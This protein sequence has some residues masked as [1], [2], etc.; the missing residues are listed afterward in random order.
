MRALFFAARADW[1]RGRDDS[2]TT[3]A[4]AADGS[5]AFERSA[6]EP[7]VAAWVSAIPAAAITIAAIVLLGPLLGRWLFPAPHMRFWP[8]MGEDPNPTQQARFL[9]SLAAPILLVAI[10]LWLV[11]RVPRRLASVLR[12]VAIGTEVLAVVAAVVCFV[13]QR[14]Q[15]PQTSTDNLAPVGRVVYF[16]LPSVVVAVAIAV[17]VSVGVRSA[18]VHRRAARWLAESRGRRRGALAAASVM[19]AVALLPAINSDRSITAAYEA[20]SYHLQFTY[21]ET[22]AVVDGRSPLGN[23][24][25]QYAALWPYGFALAMSIFGSGVL[26]FTVL[27]AALTGSMLLAL[28]DVLRHLT[29]SSAAS[30]ALFLPLL[31]T[32]GFRLHGPAVN[33]FSLINYFGVMPLRYA[34]P[35]LVAW[36]LTRHL[37]GA[38]PRRIWPLFLAAGL[39]ALNNVDFGVPALGATIAA[40][41]WTHRRRRERGLARALG[42]G[43]AGLTAALVL[44]NL[45]LLARTGSPADLSLLFRYARIFA[46]G[47]FAMYPIQP[48]VG[49]DLVIFLTYVAA[50]GTA[51]VR[52]L[53]GH[54]DALTGL[55]AWSGTF[56][57]GAG[58]YYVGHS[59]SEVLIDTFP[60]WA[61]SVTLLTL[62]IIRELGRVR[63][64]PTPAELACLV[65]LGLLVCSLAQIPL[66]WQQIQRITASAPPSFSHPDAEF[67]VAQNAYVGES[68]LIIAPLGHRIAANLDLKDVE[69]YT[70]SRSIFTVEQLE[71][72]LA[73][74]RAS[75]GTRVFAERVNTYENYARVLQRRFKV[76]AEEERMRLWVAR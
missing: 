6:L 34:G 4:E 13:A 29:R 16:T 68:V 72:S 54:R 47:G 43:I 58:S 65:G 25:S 11:R 45:L 21:D 26:V 49:L 31:A 5:D 51:T 38:R 55:L 30:L 24:A 20:V 37:D 1:P 70:G 76:G 75:G 12:P 39:V 23:F 71:Q 66:P 40:L 60:A 10:T 2:V 57:L 64:W 42:E 22:M 28:Y 74:L 59:I 56:G 32:F 48:L 18:G 36:L 27:V 73:A 46:L 35:F 44:V 7:Q 9:L 50:I 17:A 33:R 41:V 53:R 52:A 62:A 69:P 63:R 67:F 15:A 14:L 8:Q 61:L 19:T 3:R